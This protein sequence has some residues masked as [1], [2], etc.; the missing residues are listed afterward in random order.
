M[1]GTI[2]AAEGVEANEIGSD[3]GIATTIII[4]KEPEGKKELLEEQNVLT[5][6][7]KK[8]E[9]A[10]G[11]ATPEEVLKHTPPTKRKAVAQVIKAKMAAMSRIK[12]IEK[13]IE[14]IDEK[15]KEANKATVNVHKSLHPGTKV[16]IA[17]TSFSPTKEISACKLKYDKESDQIRILPL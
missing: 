14:E 9:K 3:M 16:F 15:C 8:I 6:N 13:I 7:V 12:D 1:G 17:G 10:I 11:I 2:K 5:Q 4:G